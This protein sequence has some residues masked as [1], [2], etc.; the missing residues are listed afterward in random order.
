MKSKIIA[1]AA[2]G[3]LSLQVNAANY[4]VSN[5]VNGAGSTDTLFQEAGAVNAALLDG[6]IV[7]LGYFGSNSYVPS[8]DLANIST[9][10]SD[11]TS[12]TSGLTGGFLTQLTT[13]GTAGYVDEALFDGPSILT[14]NPL[15]G[16]TVYMFVGDAAT[17]AASNAFA[18]VAVGTIL[19]ESST[20]E[21][22]FSANPT[23]TTPLIGQINA[24]AF[25]GD[26][27]P[28][29]AAGVTTFDTLQLAAVPEPSA[30]LLSA[31]GAL[32]L[33]RRKR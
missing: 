11:F 10:I 23:G 22:Q 12:V 21:N 18:L 19:D 32:A 3:A 25:T 33:L 31:F 6:G 16:R 14:G 28:G 30:L 7:S 26:P 24:G 1:L 8:A 15:I 29:A 5:L 9:T 2:L 4:A 27:V 20:P 13:A 17:L